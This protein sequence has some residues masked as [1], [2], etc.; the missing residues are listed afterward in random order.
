MNRKVLLLQNPGVEGIN[1]VPTVEAAL[2]RYKRFFISEA[3]GCWDEVNEIIEISGIHT[4]ESEYKDLILNLRELNKCDYSII[5]FIG[6]GDAYDGDDKIQLSKGWRVPVSTFMYTP[7]NNNKILKRTIIIDACRCFVAPTQTQILLED[8]SYKGLGLLDWNNSRDFYDNLVS[9]PEP[10][11]EL[12]QSTQPG[13]EAYG[14][15][16]GTAFTDTLFTVI[17]G[18]SKRW[19]TMAVGNTNGRATQ[20]VKTV[21]DIVNQKMLGYKQHPQ[22]RHW[23]YEGS[24]P[25][26]AVSR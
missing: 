13:E 14:S 20:S 16:Y 2:N 26:Y 5:V 25:L 21:Y 15:Q 6:H 11:L 19:N 17:D 8:T 23:G 18:N 7:A 12:I 24:F 1:L 3:G 10:R 4:P 9:T 22:H